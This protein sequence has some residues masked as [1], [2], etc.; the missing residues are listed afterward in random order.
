M[1]MA[2][3]K[4]FCPKCGNIGHGENPAEECPECGTLGF[5]FHRTSD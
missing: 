5:E 4:W 3:F 1:T 2:G